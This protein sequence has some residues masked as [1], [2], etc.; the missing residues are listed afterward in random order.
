MLKMKVGGMS[1]A[2]CSRSVSAAVAAVPGVTRAE[3]DLSAGEVAISGEADEAA[4]RRAIEDAGFEA[5][6]RL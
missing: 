5:G 6:A 2:H 3:V 4:V 1:C